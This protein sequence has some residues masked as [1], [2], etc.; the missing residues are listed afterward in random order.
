LGRA[1]Q[2]SEGFVIREPF[3]Y[4]IYDRKY[5]EHIAAIRSY[6]SGFENLVSMG[7]NGMHRYNNMDHAMLTGR[8]AAENVLGASHNLWNVNEDAAYLE[9]KP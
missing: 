8:M 2:V 1:D 5:R 4:P 7:R 6:L 9:K 3:A